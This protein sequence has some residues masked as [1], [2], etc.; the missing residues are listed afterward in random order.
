MWKCSRE[1]CTRSS[2]W[3]SSSTGRLRVSSARS[4]KTSSSDTSSA[5]TPRRGPGRADGEVLRESGVLVL[6]RYV[7]AEHDRAQGGPGARPTGLVVER[8]SAGRS[9]AESVDAAS[10][11]ASP[12][13]SSLISAAPVSTW[14][15]VM[16]D[17]SLTPGG[18]RRADRGLHLHRLEHHHGGAGLD[19]V[20]DG[21]GGGHDQR[22][23]GRAQHAALVAADPVGDTVDLDERGRAV[24]GGDDAVATAADDQAAAYVVDVLDQHVHRLRGVTRGHAR[25][26]SGRGR[27]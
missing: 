19:L 10:S 2:D 23:R 25:P 21:D 22:R 16:T 6:G 14:L 20:A 7:V 1:L 8:S 17:S 15:P 24:G 12:T 3:R 27:C 26:G 13:C 5:S 18:E 4:A 9:S 11:T